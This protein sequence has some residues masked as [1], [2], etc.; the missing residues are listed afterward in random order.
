MDS[1]IHQLHGGVAP[2]YPP[3]VT[4]TTALTFG[5]YEVMKHIALLRFFMELKPSKRA[6]QYVAP[7]APGPLDQALRG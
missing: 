2:E 3:I 6:R 4:L 5:V 1:F 7:A